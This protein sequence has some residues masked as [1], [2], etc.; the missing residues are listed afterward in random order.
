[1][2]C[3]ANPPPPAGYQVWRGAVPPE[4]TAWAVQLRNRIATPAYGTTWEMEYGGQLVVARKDYHSWTYR[5]GVLVT[6]ICIP[7][8]TLYSP[9]PS[10][11]AEASSSSTG[12]PLASPAPDIALFDADSGPQGS[13]ISWPLV[14]VSGTAI[15]GVVAAFVWALRSAG[16]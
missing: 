8:V 4:L 10:G 5:D 2:S 15:V 9:V 11:F 16:R 14:A 6:G 3:P 1:M 12:D 7:G 13:G